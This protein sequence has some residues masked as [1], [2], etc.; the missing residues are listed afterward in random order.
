MLAGWWL[1]SMEH[2]L[3]PGTKVSTRTENQAPLPVP[4]VTAGCRKMPSVRRADPG[5]RVGYQGL[6]MFS[7]S[8]L[9]QVQICCA[10]LQRQRDR[11]GFSLRV[12]DDLEAFSLPEG[13][14]GGRSGL[15]VVQRHEGGHASCQKTTFTATHAPVCRGEPPPP[16]A[17]TPTCQGDPVGRGEAVVVHAPKQ[18]QLRAVGQRLA[19][20]QTHVHRRA[21]VGRQGLLIGG[22]VVAPG[23]SPRAQ[24]PIE[25]A[26][27][28]APILGLALVSPHD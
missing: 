9:V 1:A 16:P 11:S 8:V 23:P 12:V 21:A 27:S 5:R 18:G 3:H 25:A 28:L 24:V 4:M 14:V 22:E 13:Q 2:I 20:A 6:R 10:F 19:A 26:A 17:A 15:V 7:C